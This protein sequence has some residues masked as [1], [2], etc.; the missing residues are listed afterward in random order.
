MSKDA[1]SRMHMARPTHLQMCP[2]SSVTFA[3]VFKQKQDRMMTKSD[4]QPPE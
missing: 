2:Y 1:K 4:V 3:I